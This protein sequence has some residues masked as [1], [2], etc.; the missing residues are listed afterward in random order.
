M[1]EDRF[2]VSDGLWMRLE[3]HLPGKASDSGVTAKDNR[4][5]L[6]AVL[7]RVRTG[8]PWRDLPSDFGNWNTQFRRFRRWAQSGVFES[9]FKAMS[10]DPDLEYA[11]IDGTI[12]QAHQKASGARGDSKSRHRA[13]AGWINN[14]DRRTRGCS[15]QFGAVFIATGSGA[16]HERRCSADQRRF[17]WCFSCR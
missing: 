7:W 16:R 13:L 14:E 15:R 4:L 17:V 8:S 9:L 6:E 10:N 3:A 1:I 5:F 2:V 11:L 12:V